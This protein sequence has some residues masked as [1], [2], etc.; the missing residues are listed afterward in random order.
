MGNIMRR[1]CLGDAADAVE[2]S[3][4]ESVPTIAGKPAENKKGIMMVDITVKNI[5][6]ATGGGFFWGGGIG[7]VFWVHIDTIYII[8]RF[9]TMGIYMCMAE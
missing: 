1:L 7:F 6:E 3:A 4:I 8:F 9:V 2:M 5:L